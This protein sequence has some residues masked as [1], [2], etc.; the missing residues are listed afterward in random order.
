MWTFSRDFILVINSWS[1]QPQAPE[2][3]KRLLSSLL[4]FVMSK[5][6]G[7]FVGTP[8]FDSSAVIIPCACCWQKQYHFD[9]IFDSAHRQPHFAAGST[10][11][12]TLISCAGK[13]NCI[14]PLK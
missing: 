11:A 1:K 5:R 9:M 14:S 10:E 12:L 4:P 6:G 3:G 13:Q 2:M 7:L 8:H